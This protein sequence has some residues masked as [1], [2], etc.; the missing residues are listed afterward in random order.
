M[1]QLTEGAVLR[2]RLSTI[3]PG[4]PLAEEEKR[5]SRLIGRKKGEERDG[6]RNVE[7]GTRERRG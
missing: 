6:K 3:D 1:T 4:D 5:T 7:D 2:H